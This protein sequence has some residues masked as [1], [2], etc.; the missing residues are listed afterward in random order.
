MC[1]LPIDHYDRT[2]HLD[3][4]VAK[5]IVILLGMTACTPNSPGTGRA[6]ET[7]AGTA[8]D[9]SPAAPLPA[10]WPGAELA[11]QAAWL[12][13]LGGP[14]A[15]PPLPAVAPTSCPIVCR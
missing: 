5:S 9:P 3:R 11:A 7:S 12:E 8:C 15:I 6:P 14:D 2:M 1:R 13:G 4:V 10:P